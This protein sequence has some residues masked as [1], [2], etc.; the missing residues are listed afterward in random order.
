MTPLNAAHVWA[1]ALL[2]ARIARSFVRT[3]Q[4]Q[5]DNDDIISKC[6]ESIQSITSYVQYDSSAAF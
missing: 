5:I 6:V 4:A 2:S 3:P 1:H